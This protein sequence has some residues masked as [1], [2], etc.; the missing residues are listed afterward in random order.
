MISGWRGWASGRRVWLTVGAW[1]VCLA[2]VYMWW[3]VGTD[4][5]W[6]PFED[7]YYA[8]LWSFGPVIAGSV[9]IYG[10]LPGLDW[11]DL[12]AVTHPHRRDA[13]AAGVLVAAFA[14]IPPLARWLF[15]LGNFYAN[16]IPSDRLPDP[17][18]LDDIVPASVFWLVAVE[19]ATVLGATLLLTAAVGR[20]IG[21][22][23]GPV[24]HLALLT[25]MGYRLAPAWFP[26]LDEAQGWL[27]VVAG[28]TVM[29]IGIAA[30]RLS[31]S[32][33]RTLLG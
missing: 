4:G 27:P 22:L 13:V 8:R 24:C 7:A 16:F 32:G 3:W 9:A 25:V 30:F 10:I 18:A 12:Q 15:G 20:L 29:A 31:R 19:V 6:A 33:A 1:V 11:V 26:R 23:T 5:P 14:L 17:N 2:L 28:V 21:P